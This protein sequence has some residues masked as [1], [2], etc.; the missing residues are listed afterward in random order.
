MISEI[1]RVNE[2]RALNVTKLRGLGLRT[3][4][5]TD[6]DAL[7]TAL[8]KTGEVDMLDTKTT[9]FGKG[10]TADVIALAVCTPSE[11][12]WCVIY[13]NAGPQVFAIVHTRMLIKD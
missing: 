3:A 8:I 7:V 6:A 2:E 12:V 1:K 9:M 13:Y 10:V 11:R 5:R 4:L